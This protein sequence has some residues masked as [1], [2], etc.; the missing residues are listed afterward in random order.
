MLDEIW[1]QK[2]HEKIFW[3]LIVVTLGALACQNWV[4]GALF[5]ILDLAVILFLK[6]KSYEQE[7]RLMRYLDD[8]SAAVEA[9]T[10]YAV[11]NLPLG[12][13][14]MDEKR[15]VVWANEVFRNWADVEHEKDMELDHLLPGVHASRLFGKTGWFD[16]QKDDLYFRV[17]HKYVEPAEEGARPFM[18]FYLMDRTDMEETLAASAEAMPV[19]C[20]IRIDNLSEALANMTDLEKSNL[21]SDVD[22]C[23]LGEF[24]ELDGFIKQYDTAEFVACISHAALKTLIDRNFDLLDKVHEIRTVNRIPVTLSIGIVKSEEPFARQA[25]EAQAALDLALGRGGDQ[26]VVRIGETVKVYGG[27]TQSSGSVTRVRVRVIAQALKEMIEES[28]RV[29]I[30]GHAHEDYD[31]LG[32]SMGLAHLANVSGKPVHIVVSKY[33][34]TSRKMRKAIAAEPGM[35][36][37]LIRE[38]EAK[39][40]VTDKTLVFITDTHI[41]DMVAAPKVLAAAKK[42]IIVDHHRRANSIVTNTLLTYMEPSASSASELVAELIQYYGNGAELPQLTASCLYAG[43]VV[44]T[45]NF[46][47]QTGIRTFDAA[48][49]L[50]RSGADT[51][52]VRGLFVLDI[53]TIRAK[54]AIM[55]KMRVEDGCIAIAEVPDDTEQAQIMAGKIADDLVAV[56]GIRVSILYYPLEKQQLGISAR[57][58]GTVNVQRVMETVGGGGHMTVSGAQI[59]ESEKEEAEAKILAAIREQLAEE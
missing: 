35:E 37:L 39:G 6:K 55:S 49:F 45:K 3:L 14:M 33:D 42:R 2:K 25:E 32:A 20:L 46:F 47:V 27:K 52:L 1:L 58:D 44:D 17:F 30:M 40:L 19:F 8:L 38:D 12:I 4:F 16:C 21:L 59:K 22:E 23:I 54:A 31:A 34:E 43:M 18:L 41:P 28:D 7:E 11:K 24:S 15:Q 9:G 29:L 10:T 48:S 53:D 5:G 50:R 56:E 26:A 57:S 13:A 36:H 51:T